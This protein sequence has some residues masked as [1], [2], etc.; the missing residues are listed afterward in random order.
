MSQGNS[1]IRGGRPLRISKAFAFIVVLI[2]L[3]SA[4]TAIAQV[5]QGRIAGIIKDQSGAVIPG[6]EVTVKN[7]RTGDERTVI[8]ADRGDYSVTA[9]KP[10]VYT[11]TAKLSGFSDIT[12][13]GVTVVV[14]QTISIE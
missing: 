12:V 11:V 9:L 10:S 8:S 5:D 2:L 14:G 3:A 13:T 4:V 1:T 6:V 7:E